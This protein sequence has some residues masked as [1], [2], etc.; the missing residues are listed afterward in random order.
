MLPLLWLLKDLLD[1]FG[2]FFL[3][4][5]QKPRTKFDNNDPEITI[6]RV[7]TIKDGLSSSF[8]P[9]SGDGVRKLIKQ[10]P[11]NQCNNDPIST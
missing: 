10:S 3:L 4:K 8:Q 6:P 1:A 11:S 2:D 7:L 5:I 9:S